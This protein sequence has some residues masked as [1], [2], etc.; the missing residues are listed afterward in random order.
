MTDEYYRNLR[1][2]GRPRR[3]PYEKKQLPHQNRVIEVT[4]T[5]DESEWIMPP[6]ISEE[7]P[8]FN[9]K[10][11]AVVPCVDVCKRRNM[12]AYLLDIPANEVS[13]PRIQLPLTKPRVRA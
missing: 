8:L 5:I 1:D 7:C 3:V 9:A 11:V 6:P 13:G 10:C 4:P 12:Y 2:K